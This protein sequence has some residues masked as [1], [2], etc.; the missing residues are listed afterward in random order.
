MIRLIQKH[1][2]SVFVSAFIFLAFTIDIQAQVLNTVWER[3]ARTGAEEPIPSWFTVG[4]VRG[5]AYGTVGGN[6]RVYA[7]DRANSTIRVMDAETGEDVTPSTAFD[8]SGVSGGTY[9]MNDI[10]VS[11]DGVI[12]LGNLAVDASSSPFRLY[13]WTSE[14]GAYADSLTVSLTDA[15]R[16]GDK[17]TVKGSVA[18]NTVEIW[19]PAAGTDP[20]VVYVATTS[21]Q[22]SSWDIEKITLSGTNASLP[23]NTDAT[24]LELGR[25]GDFY[26]AGNGTSPKRYDSSGVYIAD[27]QFSATDYTGSRNGLRSFMLDGKHHLSVYTYRPDGTDTGNK[28]GRAYVYD[29]SDAT[30]PITVGES[31]LMGDDSDTYSSI[32]GE[33]HPKVNEDGTFNIYALDGVNGF[34]A[35]TNAEPPYLD[36]PSNLYFSEYIEGSSNNKALEITNNTDSTVI[37]ANYR[38]EQSSNGGGWQYYHSFADSASIEAGGQYVLITDQVDTGLFAHEGAD[39]VLS[40]PSPIHFNGDDARAL[41]HIHPVTGDTTR[42]DVF[43]DPD[44]DPGTAW[45]V[46]GVAGAT[47][48]HTLLRKPTVTEGNTTV[49]GSFGT[50]AE[51]SEWIVKEQNDFSNLGAATTVAEPVSVTFRVNTSTIPDTVSE[52]S[53]VQIRGNFIATL[54]SAEY[55]AQNVTWD[56]GSTPVADN[57]GGDYWTVDMTMAPGDTLVY[58]YWV[59]LDESTGAAPNGGWEAGDN[60]MYVL[61]EGTTEDVTLDVV[62]FNVGDGRQAPFTTAED[63]VT[64]YFRVN[65]GAQVQDNSFDPETDKVG[66]RGAD[67]FFANGWDATA[68][69]LE[70]DAVNGDNYFYSGSAKIHKDSAAVVSDPVAYKFTLLPDGVDTDVTWEDG[71]NSTFT[72]PAADSTIHWKFFSNKPPT[73]A[74]I[75]DTELNFEVNVGILEGLGFFNSSIDTVFVR[76]TFNNWGTDNQMT[77]NSFSGTYEATSI[78]LTAAVDS[79]VKYKYYVKWDQRRDVEDSEFYLAGITHDGSGWEEPGVTGGS[80]RIFSIENSESQET[81]SEFFNGVEPEALLTESNVDGGAIT[82]T[83]S[84]D[85]TPAESYTADPFDPAVDSV[86]LFVDTPFFALTNDIVVPGDGGENFVTQPKEDIE[87]LR[88]TDEDE[89]GIYTLEL[90]LNLPTLNHIG[91]RIAYGSALSPDGELLANGGGF[92]AGRRHYQYIQPMFDSEDNVSWPATYTFPTLEWQREDLPWE[93]P[94]DYRTATSNEEDGLNTPNE[95]ELSQNYPNPFNPTTNIA[96]KLGNASNVTLSVYNVLGQKVASL[97]TNRKMTA[98]SHVVGFDA[99]QLS[100][101]IYFYRLEAGSFVQQRSMTLIK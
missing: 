68:F 82:V 58:K 38:I 98:G 41:I 39:E 1:L 45:D 28:T 56:G 20:G 70:Q 6:E 92:D 62:Y 29:V 73:D 54:D 61:P 21:D 87:R 96:F 69:I 59:G 36:T 95:F 35:Y 9:A 65:V 22:G 84:Y 16:L 7:A 67:T 43:G 57:A 94:P 52:S 97:L 48:E 12:F 81:R 31:P 91:F 27:S 49:L 23:S 99:S 14:G 78:P 13:W 42:L 101:G 93:T 46:A 33:A 63:S 100:S 37:L 44:N 75:V 60:Y 64:V 30:A 88:F 34:A 50:N 55:G 90:E 17:F 40:Y 5:M 71:D 47:S 19:M 10:E 3:T 18:D 85:M 51:D 2:L 79:D 80:D 8:L 74:V 89:D 77:F 25:S 83:F 72:M 4:S 26:V 76:G 86:Y 24:P 11:D 53:F 32:H 66:I 15:H